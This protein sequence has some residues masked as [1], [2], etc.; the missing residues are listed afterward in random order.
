MNATAGALLLLLVLAWE[1]PS[2]G[3]PVRVEYEH[4]NG[5]WRPLA[6]LPA[7]A[8]TYT[9]TSVGRGKVRCYR[10]INDVGA[11]NRACGVSR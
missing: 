1:N 8:T 9:D 5:R 7:E 11:S 3:G 2:P 4:Q 6:T 10:V